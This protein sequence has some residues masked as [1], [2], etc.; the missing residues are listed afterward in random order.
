MYTPTGHS[1][2]AYLFRVPLD[3]LEH[4]LL[5][6]PDELSAEDL[7]LADT[8]LCQRK[9][10]HSLREQYPRP[11][12]EQ[13]GV[14]RQR[15]LLYTAVHHHPRW[16]YADIIRDILEIWS[17]TAEPVAVDLSPETWQYLKDLWERTSR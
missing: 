2:E 9:E 7:A 10:A 8:I 17:L 13:W 5:N 12:L 3:K 1:M 16:V 15:Q 4:Y 14:D 11:L 6:P